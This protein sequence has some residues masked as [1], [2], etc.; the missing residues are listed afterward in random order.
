MNSSSTNDYSFTATNNVSSKE[1]CGDTPILDFS[2]YTD[3]ELTDLYYTPFQAIIITVLYPLVTAFGLF[4]NVTFL[5]AVLCYRQMRT[6]T[7]FYLANL[8][9]A[10]LLFTLYNGSTEH[11]LRYALQQ[12]LS[13]GTIHKTNLTYLLTLLINYTTYY[14]SIFIIILVGFERFMGVC[15]P[16]RSLVLR[17]KKRTFILIAV[18]WILALVTAFTC[19]YTNGSLYFSVEEVCTIWPSR[20]KYRTLPNTSHIED[21]PEPQ[22]SGIVIS[23]IT[24]VLPF[25]LALVLNAYFYAR[26]I[27]RLRTRSANTDEQRRNYVRTERKVLRMLSANA[28]VFFFCLAPEMITVLIY[29]FSG[30]KN[31]T[32]TAW[33]F[34]LYML[35]GIATNC[36]SAANPYIYSATNQDYRKV[37][38]RMFTKCCKSADRRESSSQEGHTT[39][40]EIAPSK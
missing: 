3:D 18:S 34:N 1:L 12:G 15:H 24:E 19:G 36:N 2:Q 35:S 14:A 5:I 22:A 17:S 26:I 30:D 32:Q 9:V 13:L 6:I 4:G 25:T 23:T 40:V 11:F 8:A 27:Q 37:F 31:F 7:N 28:V 16:L 39:M 20:D 33:F 21:F 10:D 29:R 38:Y